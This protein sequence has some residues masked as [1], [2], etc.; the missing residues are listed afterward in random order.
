MKRNHKAIVVI[1]Q[2][3]TYLLTYLLTHYTHL[4]TITPVVT[5]ASI[6]DILETDIKAKNVAIEGLVESIDDSTL[7]FVLVCGYGRVGKMICDLLDRKFIRYIAIESN[8]VRAEDAK[9]K[10]AHTYLLTY[11]LTHSLAHTHLLGLPVFYADVNQPEIYNTFNA[12]S[13]KACVLTFEDMATTNKAVVQLKR[14][15]P[16][17]PLL[18]R[19]KSK[20]HQE[21]LESMFENVSALSPS[22]PEDRY[23]P[24]HLLTYLLA[25]ILTNSLT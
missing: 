17:L 3:L 16:S 4:D 18:V 10:G 20:K 12:S 24:T 15:Y 11:L 9:S 6:S 14:L 1:T 7:D 23:S 2:L 25:Y 22:L 19:A 8:A 5:P 21:R 13:A